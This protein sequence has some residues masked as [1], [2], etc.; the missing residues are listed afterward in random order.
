MCLV[1]PLLTVEIDFGVA[2][3]EAVAVGRILRVLLVGRLFGLETLGAGEALDERA[4]DAEVFAAQVLRNRFGDDGVEEGFGEAV[5]F[6]ALAVLGEGGGIEG[7]FAGLQVEEPAEEK[8]EVDLFAKLAF[9]SDGVKGHQQEGFE[10]PFGRHAGAAG[11][12]VRGFE[13]GVK[14]FEDAV[15]AALDVAERMIGADAIF[16]F[17]RVEEWQLLIGTSAH[18]RLRLRWDEFSAIKPP[19]NRSFSA[20]C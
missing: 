20:P 18:G 4:I 6:Q 8:V 2:R 12:A 1:G 5:R 13:L 9:A 3:F 15:G 14:R 16:D 7:V 10:K 11:R 19:C 17:E